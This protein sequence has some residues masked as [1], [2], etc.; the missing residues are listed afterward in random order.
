MIIIMTVIVIQICERREVRGERPGCDGNNLCR[1]AKPLLHG[2]DHDDH[3]Y[4]DEDDIYNDHDDHNYD[5][6]D[7][8]YYDHDDHNY[9]YH[10]YDLEE[11]DYNDHDNHDCDHKDYAD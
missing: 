6:D 4:D 7:D 10:N 9:D 2:D 11:C 8:N 1:T 5:D 3:N